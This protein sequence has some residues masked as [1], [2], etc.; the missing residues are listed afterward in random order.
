ML[1]EGFVMNCHLVSYGFLCSWIAGSFHLRVC[2]FKSL[3]VLFD[4]F[5][6]ISILIHD[7]MI[8]YFE[9]DDLFLEKQY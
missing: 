4:G 3:D 2:S 1:E 7:L 9:L 5:V 8:Y 6:L